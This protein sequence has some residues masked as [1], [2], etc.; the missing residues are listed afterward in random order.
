MPLDSNCKSLG[1]RE[2][3]G[4]ERKTFTHNIDMDRLSNF[5]L[6]K[7]NLI[8]NLLAYTVERFH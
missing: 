8:E 2:R 7:S 3:R 4:K 5:R 6:T 1:E